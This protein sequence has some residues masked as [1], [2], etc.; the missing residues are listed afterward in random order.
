MKIY[1]RFNG[2]LIKEL[3]L[4]T[5]SYSNL[6][7]A[8]LRGANLS[9]ADLSYS[10]LSGADLR[11]TNLS[12]TNLSGADLSGADLRGTNL[13]GADLS[14]ADLSGANLRGV[15]IVIYGLNWPV[16][17][18]KNHIRIGCQAHDL[19]KWVD[20]TD[21]EIDDMSEDALSFWKENKEMIINLGRRLSNGI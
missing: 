21:D 12:G 8:N 11:G 2:E 19:D 1:N 14:G 13:S 17:I 15:L 4:E 20:F 3:D 18:T 9:G 5:L 6:R 16:F 10:N 7:G